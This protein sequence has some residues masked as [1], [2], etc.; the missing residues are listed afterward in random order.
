MTFI[1][2][3]LN[4]LKR[5]QNKNGLSALVVS[6]GLV[7]YF[8]SCDDPDIYNLDAGIPQQ[9]YDTRSTD[10]YEVFLQTV[11]E[12]SFRTDEL[13][14]DL[15]GFYKDNVIGSVKAS[16]FTELQLPVSEISF[17]SATGLDS[18]VLYLSYYGGKEYFGFPSIKQ[19]FHIYEMNE[20]IYKDSVYYSNHKF[21]YDPVEIGV[22]EGSFSPTDSTTL[23]IRLTGAFG[24]KIMSGTEDQLNKPEDF[25]N[26]IKGIAIV[27]EDLSYLGAIMYFKLKSSSTC[28][29]L[30]HSGGKIVSFPVNSYSARISTFIYN[31]SG[32]KIAE[33]VTQPNKYFESVYLQPLAG[34]KIKV[35]IPALKHLIDSGMIVIHK[36]ELL[37]PVDENS[38]YIGSLPNYLILLNRDSTGKNLNIIDR[39]ERYYNSSYD[40]INK[41]YH[42]GVVRQLQYE[43]MKFQAD[44][45][46]NKFYGFNLLIPN[47]NFDLN[48]TGYPSYLINASPVLIRQSEG[49]VKKVKLLLTYSKINTN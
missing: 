5:L 19:K 27:P 40:K 49:G 29:K 18:V 2:V 28:L 43:L 12:D 7:F 9:K 16:L 42:F 11:T 32:S 24:N 15:L 21:S 39:Y 45:S 17:D 23:S 34:T 46:F 41:Q 25:A 36:A 35:T 14:K 26:F 37:F 4:W 38:P 30:Y 48:T 6:A 8:A 3:I 33:Q 1:N 44:S 13:T 47:E 22:Y 20:R 10:T 31:Y